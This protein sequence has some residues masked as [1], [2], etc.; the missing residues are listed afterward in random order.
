MDWK[1]NSDSDSSQD[2]TVVQDKDADDVPLETTS[3]ASVTDDVPTPT[4]IA[5]GPDQA[6]VQPKKKFPA[7]LKG[8]KHRSFR[9][10]WYKQYH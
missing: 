7:T 2:C 5:T 10:D 3:R 8:N 9:A 1:G 4:D 6:P